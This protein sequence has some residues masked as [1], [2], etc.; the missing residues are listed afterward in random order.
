MHIFMSIF[1]VNYIIHIFV[2][3]YTQYLLLLFMALFVCQ[4]IPLRGVSIVI[5]CL[6]VP[7]Q[8]LLSIFRTFFSLTVHLH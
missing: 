6:S 7:V 5:V 1:V 4:F 3:I 2:L 8:V